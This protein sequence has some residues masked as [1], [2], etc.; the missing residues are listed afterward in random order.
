MKNLIMLLAM[1]ASTVG[2]ISCGEGGVFTGNTSEQRRAAL[3]QMSADGLCTVALDERHVC[4]K[5]ATEIVEATYEYYI[6]AFD[7]DLL[8]NP[9][10]N[11][12]KKDRNWRTACPDHK[13]KAK[14]ELA[15]SHAN[16]KAN[17]NI[18]LRRMSISSRRLGSS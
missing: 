11:N 17:P 16:L 18:A 9:N 4:G 15:E 2:F 14:S 5:A 12:W 10:F 7:S 1:M 8:R 3:R 6:E 13:S